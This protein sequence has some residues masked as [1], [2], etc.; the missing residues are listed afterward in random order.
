M[1]RALSRYAVALKRDLGEDKTLEILFRLDWIQARRTESQREPRTDSG[2]RGPERV[3]DARSAALPLPHY[4]SVSLHLSPAHSRSLSS[5]AFLS[6]Q[7]CLRAGG[8][9]T[10]LRM[11]LVLNPL[12]RNVTL[13]IGTLRRSAPGAETGGRRQAGRQQGRAALQRSGHED[14]GLSGP[15]SARRSHGSCRV[16]SAPAALQLERAAEAFPMQMLGRLSP[17]NTAQL[18][19]RLRRAHAQ[20]L[21]SPHPGLAAEVHLS[22]IRH[23]FAP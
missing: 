2:G 8:L 1:Q 19:E 23:S 15:A 12:D 22:T 21:L 9:Q 3:P 13:L 5:F 16:P 10:F 4:R 18:P 11:L 17:E 14:L 7:A 20:P 6:Q